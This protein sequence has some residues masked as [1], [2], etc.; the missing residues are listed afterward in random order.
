MDQNR[1]IGK[2]AFRRLVRAR[3][4]L[5]ATERGLPESEIKPVLSRLTDEEIL[6]FASRHRLSLDWL[7]SG[8]L[9]GRLRMAR[10]MP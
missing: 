5:L 2:V 7:L 4:R 8:C 3:I 10:W 6:T 1:E 9:K